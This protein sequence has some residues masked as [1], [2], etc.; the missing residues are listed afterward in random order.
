MVPV[1]NKLYTEIGGINNLLQRPEQS[2]RNAFVTCRINKNNSFTTPTQWN[3]NTPNF[4]FSKT[5]EISL[6]SEFMQYSERGYVV[7]EIWDRYSNVHDE[8]IGLVKLPLHPYFIAFQVS[9]SSSSLS[10]IQPYPVIS[11]HNYIP[12]HNPV[13]G[14]ECGSIKLLL[15]M[16]SEKQVNTLILHQKVATLIQKQWKGYKVRKRFPGIAIKS[17]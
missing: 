9:S 12:I 17:K 15:S 2:K 1:N 14:T 8:L 7:Y 10:P 5:F 11:V 16:G 13:T 6:N 3:T 4:H